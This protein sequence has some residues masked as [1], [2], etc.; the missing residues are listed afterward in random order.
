MTWCSLREGKKK[1]EAK[2]INNI[3]LN[4]GQVVKPILNAKHSARASIS[5]LIMQQNKINKQICDGYYRF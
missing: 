2:H 1:S 4:T 3:Y 5:R